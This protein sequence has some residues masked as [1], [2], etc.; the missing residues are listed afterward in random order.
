[1]AV[2]MNWDEAT[3][4]CKMPIEDEFN[5]ELFRYDCGYIES[6]EGPFGVLADKFCLKGSGC[7]QG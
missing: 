2:K 3:V 6:H 1:M 4:D 5:E 7:A